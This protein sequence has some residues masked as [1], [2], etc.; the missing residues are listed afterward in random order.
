MKFW[1]TESEIDTYQVFRNVI[2]YYLIFNTWHC[3]FNILHSFQCYCCRIFRPD[4]IF[5]TSLFEVEFKSW[6][7]HLLKRS[8]LSNFSSKTGIDVVSDFG[9]LKVLWMLLLKLSE[10]LVALQLLEGQQTWAA[11]I[12]AGVVSLWNCGWLVERVFLCLLE[13]VQE[14][15]YRNSS[16]SPVTM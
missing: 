10:L 14:G 12:V 8:K 2:K 9:C 3:W 11:S 1:T 4:W 15:Q 6:L 13:N 5:E 16:W 7:E